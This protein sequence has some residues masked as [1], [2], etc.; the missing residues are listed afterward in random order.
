MNNAVVPHHAD[1]FGPRE[2]ILSWQ[3]DRVNELDYA[4]TLVWA[5]S[6]YS[7][8]NSWSKGQLF[9]KDAQGYVFG[10]DSDGAQAVLRQYAYM[11]AKVRRSLFCSR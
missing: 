6:H 8:D 11:K 9:G 5:V 10:Y 7:T 4:C 2:G 1:Y 3:Q